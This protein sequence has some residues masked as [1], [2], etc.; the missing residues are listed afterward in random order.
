MSSLI[1]SGD[2]SG[3]ITLSAPAV[4]GSS[5]LTLPASTDTLIGRATTDTLTNKTLGSTVVQA[6]NAAPCFSAYQSTLQSVANTTFVLIAFQT[7]EFDTNN[8]FDSTTNYRFTPTVAGYY[9]IY[10]SILAAS[11]NPLLLSV[12]KN[13]V[14]YKRGGIYTTTAASVVSALVSM[15]G[16]T[17]YVD[18]R[19][20]QSSGGAI[21]TTAA[22]TVTYFNGSMV[23]SA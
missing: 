11:A 10:G 23:R 4:S 1:V 18:L 6:S 9:A 14:E 13:G 2:T 16:S 21:N 3:S 12:F 19:L 20:Y 22:A 15:N 8:N 17:D 5:V 7:E